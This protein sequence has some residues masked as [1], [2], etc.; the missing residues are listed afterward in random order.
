MQ[1]ERRRPEPR[2]P[3]L[4]LPTMNPRGA[5]ASSSACGAGRGRRALFG[6]LRGRGRLDQPVRNPVVG[7]VP[8]RDAATGQAVV[9]DELKLGFL[10]LDL[11]GTRVKSLDWVDRVSVGRAWPD[12]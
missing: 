5:G 6:L 2:A 9:A 8:A 1:E 10:S 4:K 12:T 7:H 11:A 3:W